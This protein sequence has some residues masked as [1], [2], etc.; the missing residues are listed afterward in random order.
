MSA[1]IYAVT[2]VH[3]ITH[4]S[5]HQKLFLTF[6]PY[7]LSDKMSNIGI[8]PEHILRQQQYEQRMQQIWA[9]QQRTQQA[10]QHQQQQQQQQQQQLQSQ[11]SHTQGQTQND[12]NMNISDSMQSFPNGDANNGEMGMNFSMLLF[13]S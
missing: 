12:I 13:L 3:S 2:G 8:T 11:L 6:L 5:I 4:V 10:Q 1:D 7:F 9:M